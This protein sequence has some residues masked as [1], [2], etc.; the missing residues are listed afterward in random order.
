MPS[1][2]RKT[3]STWRWRQ[4]RRMAATRL[5]VTGPQPCTRCGQPIGYGEAFDLD[6]RTPR[7]AGGTDRLDNLGVAHPTCNRSATPHRPAPATAIPSRDW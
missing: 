4:L 6:H 1:A 2:L 3:G 5:A 7:S